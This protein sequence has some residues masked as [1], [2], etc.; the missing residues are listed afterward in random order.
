ML[1]LNQTLITI[2]LQDNQITDNS[3]EY[4]SK[5]I[6]FYNQTIEEISLYSNKF[7]TDSS[8]DF[9]NNMIKTNQSLKTFWI[10]D[11]QLSEQSK[12]ILQQSI[13]DKTDFDLRL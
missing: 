4:F 5:V 12:L 3:M 10:W 13:Q 7:I 8:I 9:I 11:C 1:K 6:Q 2:G